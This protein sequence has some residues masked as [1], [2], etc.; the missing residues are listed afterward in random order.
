MV[1]GITVYEAVLMFHD[2]MNV[3]KYECTMTTKLVVLNVQ[4]FDI[5]IKSDF[6]S[7]IRAW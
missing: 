5:N 1:P 6:F 7:G 3:G 4:N 2:K